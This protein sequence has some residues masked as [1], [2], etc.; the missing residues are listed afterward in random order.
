MKSGITKTYKKK[1]KTATMAGSVM[2]T[3]TDIAW[4]GGGHDGN[5]AAEFDENMTSLKNE[6]L[7][8]DISATYEESDVSVTYLGRLGPEDAVGH[9]LSEAAL[10]DQNGDLIMVINHPP[11]RKQTLPHEMRF[12]LKF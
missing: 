3:P 9:T 4:G 1:L 6:L 12:C 8:T 11:V 7:I 5:D 2:P 10:R